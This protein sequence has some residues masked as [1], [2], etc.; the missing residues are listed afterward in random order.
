M[1]GLRRRFSK[2]VFGEE[3]DGVQ[4]ARAPRKRIDEFGLLTW[5]LL[6]AYIYLV[7]VSSNSVSDSLPAPWPS[8]THGDLRDFSQF[9][10]DRAKQHLLVLTSF[11]PRTVGTN[12][13]D[14]MSVL[15]FIREAEDIKRKAHSDV[16]IDIDHQVVSG[17][18][19][20][21][22]LGGNLCRR[23]YYVFSV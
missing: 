9:S 16:K 7:N 19:Q 3:P 12:G 17:S 21:K 22:F 20:L 14:R 1:E 8:S 4:S 11:R 10:E 18:F 13:N 23:A 6:F 5:I 2:P 15:Y